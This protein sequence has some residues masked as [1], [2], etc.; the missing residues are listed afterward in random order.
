MSPD[1][2]LLDGLRA[3]PSLSSCF[4]VELSG[5]SDVCAFSRHSRG[6]REE[7]QSGVVLDASTIG[8]LCCATQG[9]RWQ[10]STLSDR[11]V[12]AYILTASDCRCPT[13]AA[14]THTRRHSG[15]LLAPLLCPSMPSHLHL[16]R[17]KGRSPS[18]E[19]VKV[20]VGNAAHPRPPTP[21][22]QPTCTHSGPCL[23]HSK[24]T[25]RMLVPLHQSH[26]G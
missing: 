20:P 7:Q 21:F 8:N 3:V 10:S 2:S 14:N 12:S 23:F 17:G 26:V 25:S 5:S 13:P 15:A 16:E 6:L 1:P 9:F 24:V 4:W 11:G 22:A 18:L 19:C